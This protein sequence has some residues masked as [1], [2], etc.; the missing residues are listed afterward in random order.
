MVMVMV[1]MILMMMMMT[2]RR[3]M[4]TR[5]MM[6]SVYET[7]QVVQGTDLPW[8]QAQLQ[9]VQSQSFVHKRLYNSLNDFKIFLTL[10]YD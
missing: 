7:I 10:L 6:M 4:M 8:Y 2:R 1:M 9:H 5:R 3:M